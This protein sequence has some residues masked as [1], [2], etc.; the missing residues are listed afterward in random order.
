MSLSICSFSPSLPASSPKLTRFAS[1]SAWYNGIAQHAQ[2]RF[3]QEQP[4]G[5]WETKLCVSVGDIGIVSAFSSIFGTCPC[6]GNVCESAI[7]KIEVAFAR[8]FLEGLAPCSLPD[9]K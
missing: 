6:F 7:Q 4:S 3:R 9:V 1:S 8:I 2:H 5:L